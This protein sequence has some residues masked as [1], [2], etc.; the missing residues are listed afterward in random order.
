MGASTPA[1]TVVIVTVVMPLPVTDGRLKLQPMKFVAAV[2]LGHEKLT[3]PV[4][5]CVAVTV[6][7]AVPVCGGVEI[8]TA[9]GLNARLKFG[10]VLFEFQ[11]FARLSASTEP[12]PVTRLYP[13]AV[14]AL[15]ALYPKKL[16][17]LHL[18]QRCV[19]K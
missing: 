18:I 5:P 10:P 12:R 11:F 13:L 7:T 3:V 2:G 9:V 19:L 16:L 8:V 17:S 6:S 1:A 4:K 14:S 15:E